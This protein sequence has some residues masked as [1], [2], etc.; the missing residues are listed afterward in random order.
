MISRAALM[1]LPGMWMSSRATSGSDSTAAR[2]ASSAVAPS[3]QT[4]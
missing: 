1:P 3:P 2:T 4:S